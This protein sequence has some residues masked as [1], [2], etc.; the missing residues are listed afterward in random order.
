MEYKVL[1]FPN[2]LILL[3]MINSYQISFDG[4]VHQLL[5]DLLKAISRE[6]FITLCNIMLHENVIQLDMDELI[7]FSRLEL[8]FLTNRVDKLP[9]LFGST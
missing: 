1:N 8:A 9:V 5:V 2:A 3:E 7:T 6:D 4:G